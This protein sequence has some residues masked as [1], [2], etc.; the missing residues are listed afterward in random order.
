MQ[1]AGLVKTALVRRKESKTLDD[2]PDRDRQRNR[3]LCAAEVKRH[4]CLVYFIEPVG[5]RSGGGL[6]NDAQYLY[7]G[8]WPGVC[9][10]RLTNP[11]NIEH[12]DKMP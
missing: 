11:V 8:G 1:H 5:Q 2:D 10:V 6:I 4:D 3:A 7:I 9:S 12:T